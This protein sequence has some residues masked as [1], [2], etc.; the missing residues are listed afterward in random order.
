MTPSRR[1]TLGGLLVTAGEI[2][3]P[4]LGNAGPQDPQARTREL[5]RIL[6]L[7][8]P[9]PAQEKRAQ[10]ILANAPSAPCHPFKVAQWFLTLDAEDITETPLGRQY[11]ANP[12]I[13]DFFVEATST[14]H[15]SGDETWWCAAFVNWC[16]M[17]AGQDRTGS[18]ASSSFRDWKSR[19]E[20]STVHPG[21][22]VVYEAENSPS[23]G[24][25]GFFVGFNHDDNSIPTLGGNQRKG[26]RPMICVRGFSQTSP[27][28]KF[29]SF[30]RDPNW[31]SE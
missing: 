29:L 9:T 20:S 3:W 22:L 27:T 1:L 28:L 6:G 19:T 4:D 5:A 7:Q 31:P 26:G 8:P 21:D 2:F 16:L 15:P 30:R 23:H 24:H 18:A 17:R 25:V 11:H 12:I 10:R 13:V 14:A